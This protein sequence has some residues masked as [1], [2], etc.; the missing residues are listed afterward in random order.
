MHVCVG[1]GDHD[2]LVTRLREAGVQLLSLA[3]VDG[4]SDHAAARVARG[5]LQRGGLGRVGRAVVENEHLE[6]RVVGIDRRRDTGRDH[7]LLVVGGDQHGHARPPTFGFLG[8]FR[9][10]E[11]SEQD[12]SR[13]PHRCGAHRIEH[14]ERQQQLNG[15]STYRFSSL[16]RAAHSRPKTT[17]CN[18][19]R[20]R[21]P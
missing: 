19:E 11:H 6:L 8:R 10:V 4:V 18:D 13:D 5:C 16:T 15:S 9:L 20:R 3:A 12:C 21:H 2:Q 17:Q 14:D 7:G 1:V